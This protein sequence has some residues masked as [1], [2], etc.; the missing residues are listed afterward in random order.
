M[1]A[2]RPIQLSL[3]NPDD[4][5]HNFVLT[6]PG[7]MTEVGMLA[8][9]T[10]QAPDALKRQYVPDSDAVLVASKLLGSREQQSLIFTAP[11]EPGVYPFICTYPGHWRRMF[12]ALTVVAD[13]RAY[14]ADP[15]AYLAEH[16]L[17]IIDELLQYNRPSRAW[18]MAELEPALARLGQEAS[19][20]RGRDLFRVANC[21][22][23]HRVNNEG[24][25][26]GPDLTKLDEKQTPL[27]ILWNI[28]EPSRKLNENYQTHSF[29]LD[30]GKS[31]SGLI[32]KSTDDEY[33]VVVDPLASCEPVTI[34]RS[35]IDVEFKSTMSLMPLGLLDRLTEDEILQLVAYIHARGDENAQVYQP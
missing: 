21:V 5:P 10:A 16:P 8:E 17:P 18:T 35:E 20:D 1:P 25:E 15:A 32:T 12:G 31:I 34:Q 4:M 23:C 28:I 27:E 7:T 9:A 26:L 2:G 6:R 30:S 24:N 33:Q 29:V 22:A 19:F 3:S 14:E 13:L 11:E